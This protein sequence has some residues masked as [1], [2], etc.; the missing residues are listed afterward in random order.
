MNFKRIISTLLVVLM[1]MGAF[2]FISAAEETGVTEGHQIAPNGKWQTS[3]VKPT[4]DYFTGQ[5]VKKEMSKDKEGKEVWTGKYIANGEELVAT[6]EEKLAKMDLR[7]IKDGYELYVDAYSGEVATRCIATGE[8]LFSNPYSIGN[9]EKSEMSDAVKS[10][11]MSQLVVKF[12]DISTDEYEY[13]YSY[14]WA[15]SRGQITVRNVKNGIRVEYTIGR[16]E[17]R[18]LVP[19]MIAKASFE[20]KIEV[21]MKEAVDGDE[22]ATFFYKK[23]MAYYELKDP[24]ELKDSEV[25]IEGKARDS[26]DDSQYKNPKAVRDNILTQFPI[27]KKMPVYVLDSAT[28]DSEKAKIEELIKTYAPD[29]SYEDLDE[30]HMLVGYQAEDKN[31]PL[32]KMALE[33][34][35]DEYGMT[36]RLPANGIRFNESLYRLDEV[37]IL[38]YMGAG[39]NPNKGYTFFPDGSGTLFDFEK[40]ADTGVETSLDGI[41]Y[42]N[43]YAYHTISGKLEEILRYPVF[44]IAETENVNAYKTD[45]DGN[46][47]PVVEKDRGFIAMIEEG[48][49]LMTLSSYHMGNKGVYNTVIMTACPRPKDSFNLADATSVGAN[50]TWTVVSSR[51]Y[52]GNFKIRYFML[53]DADMIA[54]KELENTYEASYAGMAM[55]YRQYLVDTKVLTPIDSS[56]IKEDI[57]LYIETFG[58]IFSTQKILSIPVDVTVPLTSF[59]D[60]ATMYDE[61]SARGVE[62]IN[63]IM[64]GYTDGGLENENVPYRLK[65]EKAV[66]GDKYDFE[67]LLEYAKEKGFEL[68]PDFD[69]VFFSNDTLF[70]GMTKDKHAVKTIDNRYTSKRDYSATKQSHVSYYE[71]A[72]SPAY[73][74]RFYEKLTDNYLKTG[75]TSIS[76]STLGS[77]V[78]SDF[79]EDEPFNREDGKA[80]TVEAF[81]YL[82][83]KY[84]NVLTE[85]GNAYIWKYVDHITDVALDSSRY[86][87]SS[88]SVPFLGI[89]LHGYVQYAGSAINME[90][91]IDYAL[92]KAIESGASLK[93]ILSYQNT[94]ELKKNEVTS[95]YYS[96]RYDIWFE[97]V[98]SIYTEL[99]GLLADI[100]TSQITKHEFLNDESIRV[101]D[102]DEI[103]KDASDSVDAAIKYEIVKDDK[104]N[105]KLIDAYR[106]ARDNAEAVANA[107]ITPVDTSN[108][109]KFNG[110]D[111]AII[112]LGSSAVLYKDALGT[113]AENKDDGSALYAVKEYAKAYFATAAA[114]SD[115]YTRAAINAD[116]DALDNYRELLEADEKLDPTKKATLIALVDAMIAQVAGYGD[117]KK[118]IGDSTIIPNEDKDTLI[119]A[120][121]AKIG[122]GTSEDKAFEQVMFKY[123]KDLATKLQDLNNNTELSSEAKEAEDNRIKEITVE[124]NTIIGKY[125]A[126]NVADGAEAFK[127]AF[128]DE[129]RAAYNAHVSKYEGEYE[130]VVEDDI[131]AALDEIY[132]SYKLSSADSADSENED[133][134][135]KEYVTDDNKVVHEVFE[136]VNG[137][138]EFILNFNNY[139][140]MVTVNNVCYTVGAYGYIDITPKKAN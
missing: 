51:K 43:D 106:E 27:T 36:V 19:H 140:V 99:N 21:K 123:S 71:L 133:M 45:E 59:D 107:F 4:I 81:Q 50:A 70:D 61:L 54:E 115:A 77:Y 128:E 23:V 26:Y 136:G 91:N 124:V 88:A 10:E 118:L 22:K 29:Y 64:K 134:F 110:Q 49:A 116:S 1:L 109:Y 89:V 31:P 62:N 14:E 34:S 85:G 138:K 32:F 73:F 80:F 119:A 46:A 117:Y 97:D 6:A 35:L 105:Q 60:I 83:S 13:Y 139:S 137:K 76:V 113:F 126:R 94:D 52:T 79:D 67:G 58:A 135:I 74:S 112:K 16:E 39:T 122:T 25:E 68:F 40:I 15:A 7:F 111:L 72:I 131:Q 120:I 3:N 65:W 9:Y 33:Y 53:A 44:G 48:D 56:K 121:E 66:N 8:V 63:F 47:L 82:D 2:T 101:P 38:P 12:T 132:S 20:E 125:Q 96:I 78:N 18:L 114:L 17:A 24:Y 84:E 127:K 28:S 92:L 75:A 98:V 90:G 55:A 129:F 11:V 130:G 57:P 42:G 87:Q 103:L 5:G 86:A 100:Q 30:D 41:I 93:F 102:D 108:A 104:A 69:F 95:Q 37:K